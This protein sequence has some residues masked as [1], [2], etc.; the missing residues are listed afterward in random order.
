MALERGV[1]F[2]LGVRRER[3]QF[4]VELSSVLGVFI[5]FL[6]LGRQSNTL[7]TYSLP[8]PPLQATSQLPLKNKRPKTL[9][10]KK[11][12]SRDRDLSLFYRVRARQNVRY[13]DKTNFSLGTV[14]ST[15]VSTERAIAQLLFA[16]VHLLSPLKREKCTVLYCEENLRKTNFSSLA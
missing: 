6:E 7:I 10:K 12:K 11:K 14:Y 2:T 9:K 13:S 16:L 15:C 3:S 5:I 4:R 1:A 8:L